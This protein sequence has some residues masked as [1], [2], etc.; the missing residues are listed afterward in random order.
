MT[1]KLSDLQLQRFSSCFYHM[2]TLGWWGL[3][4]T[5]PSFKA[6]AHRASTIFNITVCCGSGWH[7]YWRRGFSFEERNVT[8]PHT[9]LAKPSARKEQI[10]LGPRR[11]RTKSTGELHQ[12]QLK[13]AKFIF[14]YYLV[15]RFKEKIDIV[16][17]HK[18]L[19][20]KSLSQGCYFFSVT[21]RQSLWGV[22]GN[23]SLNNRL[24]NLSLW[25]WSFVFWSY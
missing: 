25:N 20:N 18:K 11:R 4:L 21:T 8:S 7:G 5:L 6:Q 13:R 3:C 12:A 19:F 23:A 24:R 22:Q 16:S 15:S 2:C 1:T 14:N 10:H 9:S 17:N